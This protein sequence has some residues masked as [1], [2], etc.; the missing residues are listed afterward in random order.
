M[1]FRGIQ[2]DRKSIERP[3]KGLSVWKYWGGVQGHEGWDEDSRSYEIGR[4]VGEGWSFRVMK[5]EVAFQEHGGDEGFGA[6]RS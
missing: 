5:G 2:K 3:R 1:E 6:S 4:G